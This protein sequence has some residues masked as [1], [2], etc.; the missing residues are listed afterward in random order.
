M[1]TITKKDIPNVA[2]VLSRAFAHYILYKPVVESSQKREQFLFELYSLLTKISIKYGY[3]Y[4]TSENI[5]AVAL[6]ILEKNNDTGFFKIIK[7]G[8]IIH[9]LKLLKI[10]TLSE[11]K[12]LF[13]FLTCM[14]KV[15]ANFNKEHMYLQALAVTPEKQGQKLA[16]TLLSK[17]ID[18]CK[19][20][21]IGCYL[22]TG[23]PKNVTIYQ[24]YGFKLLERSAIA[25]GNRVYFM[26]HT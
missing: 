21:N 8:A 15:H 5:E 10:L 7:S 4:A 14:D 20:Q 18:D 3:A 6:Y 25:N 13:N 9:V 1:Y 11:I 22:E 17:L 2:K 24:K 26:H 16:S 23:D 12:R 19:K